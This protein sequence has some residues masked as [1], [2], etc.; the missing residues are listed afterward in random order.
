MPKITTALSEDQFAAAIKRA[1]IK[2]LPRRLL[3]ARRFEIRVKKGLTISGIPAVYV[4]CGLNARID[5]AATLRH[6]KNEKAGYRG[7]RKA[8]APKAQ[9]STSSE[10][11]LFVGCAGS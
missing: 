4:G 9:P 3:G 11:E 8:R 7:P 5:L 6:L 10:P 2:E 1:G